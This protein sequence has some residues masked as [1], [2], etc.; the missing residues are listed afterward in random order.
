M[1][2]A[3]IEKN[4][5][6]HAAPMLKAETGDRALV[7]ADPSWRCDHLSQ[8]FV[9][10]EPAIANAKCDFEERLRSKGLAFNV[11][12]DELVQ[13]LA[14]EM[15]KHDE[16]ISTW[17]GDL[18]LQRRWRTVAMALRPFYN[19]RVVVTRAIKVF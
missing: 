4:F 1:R 17:V 15:A 10:T 12:H 11:L 9:C 5:S 13:R 14:K 19:R 16:V 7:K 8:R 6:N 18:K 3:F 2:A